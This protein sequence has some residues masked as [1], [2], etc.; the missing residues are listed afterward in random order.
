[1]Q[2]LL[3]LVSTDVLQLGLQIVRRQHSLQVL[4][5]PACQADLKAQGFLHWPSKEELL[6]QIAPSIACCSSF[7][8]SRCASL[9]SSVTFMRLGSGNVTP[10]ISRYA[11]L[12]HLRIGCRRDYAFCTGVALPEAARIGCRLSS[13]VFTDIWVAVIGYYNYA[14]YKERPALR[15]CNRLDE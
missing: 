11:P 5:M 12:R 6:V 14:L 9:S 15:R 2:L 8:D 13:G 3:I 1:M 4:R 10:I 7:L